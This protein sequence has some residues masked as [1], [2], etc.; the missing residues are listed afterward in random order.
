[1]PAYE[2][3]NTRY[4]IGEDGAGKVAS[5][6]FGKQKAMGSD[7]RLFDMDPEANRLRTKARNLTK[8]KAKREALKKKMNEK[9]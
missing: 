8:A 4:V 1:M 2:E 5:N 6:F 9:K 7:K 3:N